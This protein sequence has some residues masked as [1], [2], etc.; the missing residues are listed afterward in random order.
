MNYSNHKSNELYRALDPESVD[1]FD[2]SQATPKALKFTFHAVCSSEHCAG[3]K[4]GVEKN[5]DRFQELCKDCGHY[6][7][8]DRREVVEETPND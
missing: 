2:D 8:W 5:V 3:R 4:I 6:L 7:Y 1:D